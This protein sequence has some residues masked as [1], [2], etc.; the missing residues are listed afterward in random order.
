MR[1][2]LSGIMVGILFVALAVCGQICEPVQESAQQA[3]ERIETIPAVVL[4]AETS[5]PTPEQTTEPIISSSEPHGLHSINPLDSELVCVSDYIPDLYIELRY[6]TQDNFT[7]RTIYDFSDA[8]LRYGTVKKLMAVQ[9]VLRENGYSLKIW[10]AYRPSASQFK[11]WEVVPDS[12]Y[13][14]NPFTGHS[15]HS[16]GGTIDVTV[17]YQD[18]SPVEMPTD[19]DDFSLLADRDYSD[20]SASARQNAQLLEQ[21]M[22]D[23]G[24]VPYAGEWW[25]FSD[26][27]AYHYEDL[28]QLRFPLNRQILY[29]PDCEEYISLRAKPDYDAELLARVP[30]E[31]AFSVIGWVGDFARI[32]YQ[33]QP[34]Y[35]A[36]DFIQ[37]KNEN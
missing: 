3:G 20:V 26:P 8:W 32:E 23:E 7:G 28:E 34:G 21:V 33:G 30:C 4:P 22:K 17:V 25:H 24:F 18:G 1:R 10:D 36:V 35:V 2:V 14:A 37:V 19:F 16:S 27:D 13:V 6:A 31:A 29:E 15:S 9:S 12:T 5:P 11:L